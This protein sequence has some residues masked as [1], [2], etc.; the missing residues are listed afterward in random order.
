MMYCR[1]GADGLYFDGKKWVCAR[2]WL[3]LGG[4]R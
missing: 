3:G 4:A 1:C 2:C